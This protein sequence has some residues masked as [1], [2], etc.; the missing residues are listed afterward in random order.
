MKRIQRINRVSRKRP[1]RQSRLLPV[2]IIIAA[3]ALTVQLALVRALLFDLRYHAALEGASGITQQI[4]K[5]L[6]LSNQRSVQRKLQEILI[7]YAVSRPHSGFTKNEI[8]SLYLNSVFF[9]SQ[10]TG[11]EA[12]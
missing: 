8:L 11:V 3:G 10:A 1:P 5:Q 6:V 2:A 4:V 7:A 12:A 9:G